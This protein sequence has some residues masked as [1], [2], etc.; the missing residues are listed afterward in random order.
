M[1]KVQV[2]FEMKDEIYVTSSEAS[3]NDKIE[4]MFY[5]I[6]GKPVFNASLYEKLWVY[7]IGKTK[8]ALIGMELKDKQ[9]ICLIAN[10][11]LEKF[12]GDIVIKDGKVENIAFVKYK[13]KKMVK[14]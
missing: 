4:T 8:N 3:D 9:F 7:S 14:K 11:K 13:K 10:G 2:F 12:N 1:Q 6:N 5:D